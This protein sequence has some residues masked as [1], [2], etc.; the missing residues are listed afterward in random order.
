MPTPT[1]CQVRNLS[2]DFVKNPLHFHGDLGIR[3]NAV[4]KMWVQ[5]S[6]L[7]CTLTTES[8]KRN[9]AKMFL[10]NRSAYPDEEVRQLVAFAVSDVDMRRVCVHVKNRR[11]APYSGF[12]YD[13]VPE[14][15][16]APRSSKYLVTIGLGPPDKF[17]T[18]E[19]K[20]HRGAGTSFPVRRFDDWREALVFLAA[21]EAKHIEQYREGLPRSEVRCDAFA[22]H[23]LDRY[24]NGRP[25]KE[26]SETPSH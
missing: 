18:K 24:R 21:H 15:S 14:I 16:N 7:H 2:R 13:H 5:D 8:A 17:P 20:R 26:P 9:G 3:E 4:D 25:P 23:M 10:R 1:T 19:H 11:H 22:T 12:A 6:F